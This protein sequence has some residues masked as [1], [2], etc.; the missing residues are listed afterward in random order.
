[1][2]IDALR[3]IDNEDGYGDLCYLLLTKYCIRTFVS[4]EDL[5]SQVNLQR[6][7]AVSYEEALNQIDE[8]ASYLEDIGFAKVTHR[9]SK[10][11][12]RKTKTNYLDVKFDVD[13]IDT[14]YASLV[15]SVIQFVND[16]GWANISIRGSYG[17]NGYVDDE[18]IA[19]IVYN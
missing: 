7:D 12:K 17:Y 2:R 3:Y 1:M 5:E 11:A 9:I 8:I 13:S 19:R 10:N 16:E 6:N 14:D 4:V 15:D 18:F